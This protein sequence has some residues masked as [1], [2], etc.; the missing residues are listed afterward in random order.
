MSIPVA[1]YGITLSEIPGKTA[2]FLEIGN[3]LQGCPGCHSPHLTEEATPGMKEYQV[4][5]LILE[6]LSHYPEINAVV[7]MGGT[8]NKYCSLDEI[9]STIAAIYDHC[10]IPCGLYS[11]RDEDPEDFADWKGL[12]WLKTGSYKADKGGLESPTTNQRFYEKQIV[13]ETDNYGCYVGGRYEF[14]NITDKFRQK[15]KLSV[16][17]VIPSANQG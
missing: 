17:Q 10:N 14:I 8:A 12:Y 6:Q 3:C 9:R 16:K 4:R 2:L 11:G 5:Q 7:F 15:G 13:I 1:S